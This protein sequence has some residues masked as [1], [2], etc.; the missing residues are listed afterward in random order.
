M[1]STLDDAA[2]P[3]ANAQADAPATGLPRTERGRLK[4][5]RR[6]AILSSAATL[7]AERGYAGVTI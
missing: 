1:A 5:D 7:F 6:A 3:L 2:V 4:A